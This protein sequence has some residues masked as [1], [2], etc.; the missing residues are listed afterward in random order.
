MPAKCDD[1]KL[2]QLEGCKITREMSYQHSLVSDTLHSDTRFW[3]W[4]C[5]V[6]D[7]ELALDL[8]HVAT[9][10]NSPTRNLMSE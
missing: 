2:L 4:M 7:F 5:Q 6:C 10:L 9:L 8:N 1:G 3:Y